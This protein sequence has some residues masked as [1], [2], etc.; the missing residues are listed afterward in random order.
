M[1]GA[2]FALQRRRSGRYTTVAGGVLQ[3][4][5]AGHSTYDIHRRISRTSSWRIYVQSK[6]A[7]L[8]PGVG[9]TVRIEVI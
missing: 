1:D 8:G 5:T 3:P 6:S 9:R 7:G 4:G 2:H